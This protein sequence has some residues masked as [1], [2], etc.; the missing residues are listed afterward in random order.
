M[1]MVGEPLQTWWIVAISWVWVITMAVVMIHYGLEGRLSWVK[2]WRAHWYI[3]LREKRGR[4]S[5]LLTTATLLSLGTLGT[6]IAADSTGWFQSTDLLGVILA[7]TVVTFTT[8]YTLAGG[9]QDEE[10]PHTN[11]T[12]NNDNTNSS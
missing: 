9:W 11:H 6:V 2:D 1:N 12:D 10:A 7:G 5:L 3:D 4:A 8:G